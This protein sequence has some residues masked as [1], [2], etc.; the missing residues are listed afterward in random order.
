MKADFFKKK[1]NTTPK[2]KKP[3]DNK[4]KKPKSKKLM[5]TLIGLGC[6]LLIFAIYSYVH[7]AQQFKT[8]FYKGTVINGIDASF[9]TPADVESEIQTK[10]ED[11]RIALQFR[12]DASETIEGTDIDYHYVS[13]GSVQEL[14]DN[15]HYL[16]W[17]KG[18]FSGQEA[19]LTVNTDFDQ[20][21]L[22]ELVGKL[23]ELQ[24]DNMAKPKNAKA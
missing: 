24:A 15:Q 13:D 20:E 9:R 19:E 22:T 2:E 17:P 11:Y 21:K 12:E 3:K 6:A 10:A 16:L 7:Y 5:F 18:H 14:F 8:V 4:P 1:P 23:P